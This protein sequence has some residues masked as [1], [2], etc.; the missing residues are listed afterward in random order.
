M[1]G[2]E[3]GWN[4]WRGYGESVITGEKG[5]REGNKVNEREGNNWKERRKHM[6]GDGESGIEREKG[7]KEENKEMEREVNNWKE[8]REQMEGGW[9]ERNKGRER[10][11]KGLN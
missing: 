4:K 7:G 6:E 10:R 3:E 9:R 2:K 5:G 8:W 1:E 11:E